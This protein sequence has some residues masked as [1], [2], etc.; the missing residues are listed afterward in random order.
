MGVLAGAFVGSMFLGHFRWEACED[1]REL[2]RQ[3]LGAA[4]MGFGAALA[5]GC[6]I[7]QGLTAMSTLTLS[8]PLVLA[9]ILAGAALGLRQIMFGFS[10]L[11]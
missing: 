9:S 4:L 10:R 3:I 11:E 2:R 1:P 5:L 7:G 6:S 8:A